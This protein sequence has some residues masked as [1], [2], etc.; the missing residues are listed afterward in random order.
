[1]EGYLRLGLLAVGVSIVF[2]IM[3]EAWYRRRR[4]SD[5]KLKSFNEPFFTV[6]PEQPSI[7][8]RPQ[9]ASPTPE[10]VFAPEVSSIEP[11]VQ[12]TIEAAPA[13]RPDTGLLVMSVVA[14]PGCSFASY[15]L[16]QAITA[17]GMR[18]GEMNI[19]H[20]YS[21]TPGEKKSLFSLASATEPGEFDLNRMGE[22]SCSGLTLFM[23]LKYTPNPQAVVETMM[24]TA[25]QL[26][27]YLDGELRAGQRRPWSEELASEFRQ[28]ALSFS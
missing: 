21:Q 27:E 19:F 7:S 16:L 28:R 5:Q 10:P 26:A 3:L 12:P 20:Y 14:R 9:L 1:M 13:A 15:D 23:E 6:T 25:E 2:L 24:R 17:T 4:L 11:P 22:Y 18:F 8:L